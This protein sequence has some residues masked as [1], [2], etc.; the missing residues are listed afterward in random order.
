L[1]AWWVYEAKQDWKARKGRLLRAVDRR[2]R[3][4]SSGRATTMVNKRGGQAMFSGRVPDVRN[5]NQCIWGGLLFRGQNQE[6]RKEWRS[7]ATSMFRENIHKKNI[8]R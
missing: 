5:V 3:N 1:D 2:V 6:N 7:K 4:N 8:P